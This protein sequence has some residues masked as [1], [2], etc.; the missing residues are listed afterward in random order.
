M[1]HF[2]MKNTRNIKFIDLFAGLGGTRIGFER[3]LKKSSMQGVCVFTSE[4]KSE[5]VKAYK[6][7]FPNDEI[8]GDITLTN[9]NDI[10]DFDVLLAGFPCQPFSSAGIRKGFADTRGTLFFDI[11]RILKSKKPAA[12]ILENVEGLT[13]HDRVDKGQP[14]G[15]TLATILRSLS[16]L[17]YVVS[18]KVLDS[19]RFGSPQKR[20]RIYIVGTKGKKISLENFEQREAK[21]ADVIVDRPRSGLYIKS[22]LSEKLLR[23]YSLDYLRGKQIKDK[24][25][26]PNNI[27]SWDIQLKGKVTT[28]QKRLLEEILKQRRRKSW[29]IQKR[30]KWSDGMPLTLE[31]ISSF[32]VASKVTTGR[33]DGGAKK[34]KLKMLLDDLVS[35][36]YMKKE[37]PKNAPDWHEKGYNIIAGKL[38]FQISH[39]LDP[40]STTP[41]L[42]ATDVT[43]LA[44]ADK[45][46]LR[47]LDIREGLRLFGFPEDYRLEDLVSYNEAF[48]LL[49]NSVCVQVVEAVAERVLKDLSFGE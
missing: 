43:R 1:L 26:G 5:A 13:T 42:V 14:I 41:T 17:G 19:S 32:F 12:F 47:R 27:H 45:R 39:I 30:I 25:G 49:G 22:D 20:K 28:E 35:K 21:L 18:W 40:N 31:E 16:E 7:N 33:E 2:R 48:D 6:T 36:G 34:S 10:P 44:L 8:N 23:Y 15:R 29:A 3:A 4:I 37:I 9:A 11:E 38:S 46:G 24:R